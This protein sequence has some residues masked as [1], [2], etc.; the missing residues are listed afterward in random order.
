MSDTVTASG[1][2]D[3]CNSDL[4]DTRVYNT[5]SG[6]E[7]NPRATRLYENCKFYDLD[8]NG[9]IGFNVIIILYNGMEAIASGA[10]GSRGVLRL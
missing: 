2:S 9:W 7:I 3:S 8:C 6:R 4:C 5:K 10:Y 1:T